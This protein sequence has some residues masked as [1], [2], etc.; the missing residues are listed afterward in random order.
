[1]KMRTLWCPALAMLLGC[2]SSFSPLPSDPPLAIEPMDAAVAIDASDAASRHDA[3]PEHEAATSSDAGLDVM[4]DAAPDVAADT[5]AIVH[6]N[7]M[8][9]HWT[10]CVP[11][12]TYNETQAKAACAALTN[13][14]AA[15]TIMLGGSEFTDICA[16]SNGWLDGG[17]HN[18]CACWGF[19][20]DA[21]NAI[22]YVSRG[23]RGCEPGGI[24]GSVPWR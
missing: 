16:Q 10:D 15:C 8:G 20:G 7:G 11:L 12:G 3:L 6:D 23:E 21:P 13:D 14:P 9:G 4:A 17:T 5:C 18:V 1:M 22:G 19:A 24:A 2:G